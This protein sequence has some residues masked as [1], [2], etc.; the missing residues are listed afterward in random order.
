MSL[1]TTLFGVGDIIHLNVTGDDNEVLSVDALGTMKLKVC[2]TGLLWT[3]NE[4]YFTQNP[5][6][7]TLLPSP[8]AASTVAQSG[9]SAWV[10]TGIP[11]ILPS[12]GDTITYLGV[13]IDVM[14]FDPFRHE[15]VLGANGN[16][17]IR[18]HKDW[19]AKHINDWNYVAKNPNSVK[20][21]P[22]LT[23]CEHMWRPYQSFTQVFDI[24]SKCDVKK[25]DKN[26]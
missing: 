10:P 6:N 8:V 2:N 24:C 5:Q 1:S 9:L 22:G 4:D 11:P 14:S 25:G 17:I 13:P 23:K 12:V 21:Q 26:A 19:F 20:V 15:Y 18:L 7:W 3:I 16:P